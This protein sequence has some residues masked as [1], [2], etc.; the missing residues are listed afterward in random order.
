MPM[1]VDIQNRRT[2]FE[3]RFSA[4]DDRMTNRIGRNPHSVEITSAQTNPIIPL[5]NPVDADHRHDPEDKM[6]KQVT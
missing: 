6:L 3:E 4:K 5:N 1:K 2:P